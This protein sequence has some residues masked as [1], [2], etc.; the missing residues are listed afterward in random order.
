M[1]CKNIQGNW[2]NLGRLKIEGKTCQTN[3]KMNMV[4]ILIL[5][6]VKLVTKK[7]H[8]IKVEGIMATLEMLG[9]SKEKWPNTLRKWKLRE[10]M[11]WK[12]REGI[13]WKARLWREIYW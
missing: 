9:K 11:V 6:L 7:K 10:G 13:G 3:C 4:N 12:L 8:K 2:D 5:F 1:N